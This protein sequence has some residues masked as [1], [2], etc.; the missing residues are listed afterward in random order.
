MEMLLSC[1]ICSKWMLQKQTRYGNGE[2]IVNWRPPDGKGLCTLLQTATDPD[3]CCNK[4]YRGEPIVEVTY[5]EG[6]PWHHS[7]HGPC[8][9]CRGNGLNDNGRVDDRCCGTGIVLHYDDGY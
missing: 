5:K 8:P 9:D 4:F 7:V 3:F 1:S 2:V 6:E